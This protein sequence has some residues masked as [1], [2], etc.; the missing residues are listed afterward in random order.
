M[1]KAPLTKLG[2]TI[3]HRRQGGKLDDLV[4]DA[5]YSL[6]SCEDKSREKPLLTA[7]NSPLISRSPL[8]LRLPDSSRGDQQGLEVSIERFA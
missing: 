3:V 5:R 2:L 7:S 6:N 1:K 8:D 4:L